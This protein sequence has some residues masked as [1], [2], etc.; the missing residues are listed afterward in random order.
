MRGRFGKERR[1]LTEEQ[2]GLIDQ[3]GELAGPNPLAEN[4]E[5]EERGEHH[6][7]ST[8]QRRPPRILDDLAFGLGSLGS[9]LEFRRSWLRWGGS[10]SLGAHHN[11]LVF[12]V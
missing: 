3:A 1:H 8:H 2:N 7:G 5:Q 10:L 4:R 9:V 12:S 11:F 6:Q